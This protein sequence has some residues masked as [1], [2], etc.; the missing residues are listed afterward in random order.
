MSLKRLTIAFFV[1]LVVR[2]IFDAVMMPDFLRKLAGSSFSPLRDTQLAQYHIIAMLV[3]AMVFVWLYALISRGGLGSWRVGLI[4]GVLAALLVSLPTALHMYA[5]VDKPAANVAWPVLWTILTNA[6][7]G[8][9][10]AAIVDVGTAPSA[11][12]T[13]APITN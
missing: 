1:Y 11:S 12:V 9:V 6:V 13:T 3:H 7:G 8:V 4:Y 2:F 5:M 10:V